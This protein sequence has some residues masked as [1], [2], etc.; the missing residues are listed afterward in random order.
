MPIMNER[1]DVLYKPAQSI[2]RPTWFEDLA[3]FAIPVLKK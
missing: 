2:C 3:V 1:T